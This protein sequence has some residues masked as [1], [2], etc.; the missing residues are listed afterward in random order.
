[1]GAFVAQRMDFGA[2]GRRCRVGKLRLGV[3]LT[4]GNAAAGWRYRPV[5]GA[6]DGWTA[7]SACWM[8]VQVMY[9]VGGTAV[10]RVGGMMRSFASGTA[11]GDEGVAD[12][13]E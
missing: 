9:A 10:C 7:L 11:L 1:M 12:S 5:V 2:R 3:G 8:A 6:C 13:P 4:G